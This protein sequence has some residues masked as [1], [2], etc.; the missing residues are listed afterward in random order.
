MK[1]ELEFKNIEELLA[2]ITGLENILDHVP[3]D[4]PEYQMLLNILY[5]LEDA[6]K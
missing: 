2:N 6:T 3:V 1:I 5:K 4:V